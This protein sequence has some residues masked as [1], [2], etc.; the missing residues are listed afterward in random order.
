MNKQLEQIQR[1]RE[2]L[3]MQSDL[4]RLG[5]TLQIETWKKPLSTLDR[6]LA[7][8]RLAREHRVLISIAFGAL[9]VAGRYRLSRI[10]RLGG[11]AWSLAHR[12]INRKN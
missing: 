11:L 3:V 8:I 6:A 2:L 1:R 12:F 7:F 9:A 4:Q 5:L 10:A